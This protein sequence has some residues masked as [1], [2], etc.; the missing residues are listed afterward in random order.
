MQTNLSILMS[1]TGYHTQ[2]ACAKATVVFPHSYNTVRADFGHRGISYV[3][4]VS[5]YIL[6]HASSSLS[7]VKALTI[8]SYT[9]VLCSRDLY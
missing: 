6:F 2:I 7:L 1:H 9:F 5:A 8:R 3:C 4:R